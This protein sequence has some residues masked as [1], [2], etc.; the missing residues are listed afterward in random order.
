M[1]IDKE[2]QVVA[3]EKERANQFPRKADDDGKGTTKTKTK[4]AISPDVP[5]AVRQPRRK[6]SAKKTKPDV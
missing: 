6:T 2:G 1:K 3:K 5:K 4:T